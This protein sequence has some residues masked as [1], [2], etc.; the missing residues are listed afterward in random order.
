MC[1]VWTAIFGDKTRGI[2]NG[3]V[4]GDAVAFSQA[5]RV[6]T[7]NVVSAISL[8]SSRQLVVAT[9]YFRRHVPFTVT[10]GFLSSP[11]HVNA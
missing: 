6:R 1:S 8:E 4:K 10:V 9:I 11:H 5:F 7:E 3:S 2:A